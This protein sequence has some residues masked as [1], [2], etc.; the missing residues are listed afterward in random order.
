MKSAS[1]SIRSG[2]SQIDSHYHR[3]AI[4]IC[5]A[6][7]GG[8]CLGNRLP[9]GEIWALG[10]ALCGVALILRR[11]SRERSAG[12]IPLG[13]LFALGYFSIQPYTSPI[14]SGNHVVNFSGKHPYEINGKVVSYPLLRNGRQK[15]KLAVDRLAADGRILSVTGHLQLT[16]YGETPA[17]VF[18]DQIRFEGR[19]KEMRNFYNPGGFDYERYMAFQGI[20]AGTYCRSDRIH[21]LKRPYVSERPWGLGLSR[22]EILQLIE[23]AAPDQ[24]DVQAVLAALL[25]GRKEMLSQNIRDGFNHCGVGHLLA[26]SGLHMGI[27]ALCSFWGLTRILSYVPVLLWRGIARRLAVVPAL[28]LVFYYGWLAD[29][30]PSTQRAVLMVAIVL[31]TYVFGRRSDIF[32]TLAWAAVVILILHPPTLFPSLF[33]SLSPQC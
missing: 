27:V 17:L 10:M 13:L 25:I 26:I 8:I 24:P 29:F 1:K 32:N 30:S 6:L 20:R 7:M 15:V 22:L 21:F 5:L 11:I 33:S 3:P 16:V 2:L 19:I 31:G 18:G 9:R 23:S 14:L 12:K 28:M 4:P